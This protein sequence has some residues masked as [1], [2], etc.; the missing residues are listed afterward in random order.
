VAANFKRLAGK[1]EVITELAPAS[2]QTSVFGSR[3]RLANEAEIGAFARHRL[4][5]RKHGNDA[6]LSANRPESQPVC[7]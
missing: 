2:Q 5:D 1:A 4:T 7:G 6:Q 3:D